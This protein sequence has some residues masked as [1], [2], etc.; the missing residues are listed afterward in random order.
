MKAKP[1]K[2]SRKTK[3]KPKKDR[4]SSARPSSRVLSVSTSSDESESFDEAFDSDGECFINRME[5]DAVAARN[6][7]ECLIAENR[8]LK[9]CK[10]KNHQ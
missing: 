7:G 1:V 3:A 8:K 6:F 4:S 9:K 10:M 5:K 2:K